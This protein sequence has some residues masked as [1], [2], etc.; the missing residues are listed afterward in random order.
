MQGFEGKDSTVE[1]AKMIHDGF[2]PSI[3]PSSL[4]FLLQ[5]D[6]LLETI[7]QFALQVDVTGRSTEGGSS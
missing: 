4:S 7:F 3:L 1:W 5:Q 6:V 2:Q